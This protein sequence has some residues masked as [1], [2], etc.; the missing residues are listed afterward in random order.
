M[1][2]FYSIRFRLT[3]YFLAIILAVM[4]IISLFLYSNLER[5]YMSNFS[6][7]LERSAYLAADFVAGQLRGQIDSVRLSTLAENMSRQSQ[8]RVIFSDNQGLVVGDSLR[9]GG[10]LNQIL[11]HEDLRV[12]LSGKASS[13][14]VYSE[15]IGYDVMQLAV[16][17]IDEEGV[18]HGAVFLSASL[19]EVYRILY[20]IRRYLYLS[21]LLAMAVVGGGSIVLARRFTGPLEELTLAARKMAEGN[22]D[23]HISFSAGDEIGRLAEQF[24]VMA[25]K[26]NYYTGNLKKFA[27][28]VAH[29]VRTPLTTMTLLTKAL[30]EHE[31]EP[32]Q[33]KDFLND[34]D[35]ELERLVALVNDL[36]E[37]SKLDKSKSSIAYQPLNLNHF[38][39]EAVGENQYR[40]AQAGLELRE[41]LPEDE[42]IVNCAPTQMR[43]VIG[44]LLDNAYNYT[45]AGGTITLT[46]Y[47]ENAEAVTV[48]EDTGCG[49]P[50]EDLS[51]VFERFFRV[52]RARSREGGGTGLGLSIVSEIATKHGGRVWVE[53]EEG[54]GSRFMFAL[55][56]VAESIVSKS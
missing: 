53:S 6:G 18:V 56:L 40:Y 17:V 28:D 42:L 37:L 41:N 9:I 23:Q 29:E 55:P 8:A 32:E 54:V 27:A 22:L 50:Q 14:I 7:S 12:A 3:A 51:F 26:I 15:R 2:R 24:N 16:P 4:I 10:L 47:R 38:L 11:D 35:N 21:T 33:R 31:M 34:L 20:D 46:L 45:A 49:I 1:T 19:E 36:L 13:S 5:Y 44:N 52:D 48:V 43:Q 25:R 30:K 39:K